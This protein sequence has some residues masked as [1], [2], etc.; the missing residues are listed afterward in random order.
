MANLSDN[1][2][3][4]ILDFTVALSKKAGAIILEGSKHVRDSSAVT[5]KVN[6]VDLVTE[7]DLKVEQYVQG[8]IANAYPHFQL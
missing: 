8:E 6:A 3:V 1:D 5:E 4:A 2:L 7:W